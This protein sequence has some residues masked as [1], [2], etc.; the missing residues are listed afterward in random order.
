MKKF[1]T[2]ASLFILTLFTFSI[3]SCVSTGKTTSKRRRTIEYQ[4][5]K[6]DK[7]REENLGNF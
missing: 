5:K 6:L 4:Q 7:E 2:L 1:S 3:S